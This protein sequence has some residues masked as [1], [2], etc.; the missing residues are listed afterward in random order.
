MAEL[1]PE[2]VLQLLKWLFILLA[3]PYFRSLTLKHSLQCV[4]N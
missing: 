3:T 2:A 4:G 1:I